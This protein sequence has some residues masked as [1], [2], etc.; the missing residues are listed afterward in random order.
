MKIYLFQYK[1]PHACC[2]DERRTCHSL[3]YGQGLHAGQG[4]SIACHAGEALQREA[5]AGE[6]RLRRAFGGGGREGGLEEL[7]E[8]CREGSE[9]QE[10]TV[11]G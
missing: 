11:R 10:A 3:F 6:G 2:Y 8:D 5:I 4:P 1:V 9:V 7:Q